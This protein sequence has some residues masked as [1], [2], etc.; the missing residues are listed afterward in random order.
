MPTNHKTRI[1]KIENRT[2]DAVRLGREMSDAVS[3]WLNHSP[4]DVQALD[5]T[6]AKIQAAKPSKF[7]SYLSALGNLIKQDKAV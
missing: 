4:V 1:E 2:S 5:A 6:I 3:A 7:L